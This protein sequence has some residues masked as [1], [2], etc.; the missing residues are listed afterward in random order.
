[1]KDAR[2][3]TS[4]QKL[5]STFET[6]IESPE[7]DMTAI[8]VVRTESF[9]TGNRKVQKIKGWLKCQSI[10]SEDKKK[11]LAHKKD[12]SPVK[13][14]QA[15]PGSKHGKASPKEQSEGKEKGKVQVELTLPTELQNSKEKIA[16]DNVFNMAR[17]LMEFKNK[18]EE[19]LNQ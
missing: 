10:L 15:S 16:M 17:T 7:A 11:G 4:S 9:P 19:R 1:M 2:A 6:L 8:T 18:E 3:S 13:A 14:P 12:N 5:A